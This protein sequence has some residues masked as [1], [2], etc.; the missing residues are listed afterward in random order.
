MEKPTKQLDKDLI[1]PSSQSQQ[2]QKNQK[3]IEIYNQ[4]NQ[5]S[6][7]Q[8][9]DQIL[10]IQITVYNNSPNE[11]NEKLPNFEGIQYIIANDPL[12]EL[13]NC[14]GILIKQEPELIEM[15]TGFQI[16]NK[17]HIF[18]KINNGYIY[19][20]K[21]LEKSTCFMRCCCDATLREFNMDILHVGS[22]FGNLFANIYKPF[23]CVCCNCCQR[24]EMIITL[25]NGENIGKILNPFNC[26]DPIFIVYDSNGQLKYFAT[27]DCCQCGFCCKCGKVDFIIFDKKNGNQIGVITK[28]KA[29]C[30]EI[31]SNADSYNIEFPVSA[32]PKEKLLLICLGLMI[33]YQNFEHKPH[34]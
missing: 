30:I 14:S 28:I 27:A 4:N 32:T 18:G 31:I 9:N 11:I 5:L 12:S 6:N 15:L 24:P 33:D 34:N 10:S 17:Y 25:S 8:S 21:C 3:H 19:L 1:E 16:P 20:F 22:G 29:Q 13:N 23:K 7:L 2:N 26:S